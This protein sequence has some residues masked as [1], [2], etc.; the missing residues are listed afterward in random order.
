M[1]AGSWPLP[2]LP[3]NRPARWP[4]SVPRKSRF[5]HWSRIARQRKLTIGL[6]SWTIA[7]TWLQA[8]HDAGIVVRIQVNES[9]TPESGTLNV[10]APADQMS[11]WYRQLDAAL[12]AQRITG[13][14]EEIR[15]VMIMPGGTFRDLPAP[16][17]LLHFLRDSPEAFP[18]TAVCF[19]DSGSAV[20]CP[21]T[22]APRHWR[23][24]T[25]TR[26]LR[27]RSIWPR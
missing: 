1:P 5:C 4:N 13:L 25:V 16:A 3:K 8:C 19:T 14:N 11:S 6:W 27:W 20:R 12:Q 2:S 18:L 17:R 23:S 7:G 21:E 15:M 24:W 26:D 10:T 22:Q 9:T